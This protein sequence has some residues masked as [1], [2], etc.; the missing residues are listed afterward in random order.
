MPMLNLGLGYGRLSS[1]RSLRL[2]VQSPM[3]LKLGTR[4]MRTSCISLGIQRTSQLWTLLA[5]LA[6]PGLTKTKTSTDASNING[7]LRY[8]R[9]V[10]SCD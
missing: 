7:R 1:M 6:P 3:T 10:D 5:G 9:G 2:Y 8:E 4:S